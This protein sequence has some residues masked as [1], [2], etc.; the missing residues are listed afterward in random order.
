MAKA[1]ETLAEDAQ[2]EQRRYY[3]NA[4]KWRRINVVFGYSAAVLALAA[5][6][7]LFTATEKYRILA[8]VA[9]FLAAALS[10]VE[11][12]YKPAKHAQEN[13]DKQLRFGDLYREVQVKRAKPG[14]DDEHYKICESLRERFNAIDPPAGA[15]TT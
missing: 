5:G 8:G 3:G 6:S 7:A 14:S 12:H 4:V 11:T 2:R 9:G 13:E 1:Y 10:L 15:R